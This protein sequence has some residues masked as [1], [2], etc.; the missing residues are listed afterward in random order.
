MFSLIFEQMEIFLPVLALETTVSY[1]KK[2][3]I[4]QSMLAAVLEVSILILRA[5]GIQEVNYFKQLELKINACLLQKIYN[6]WE[7]KL[8]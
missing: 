1:L 6:S 7:N 5:N 8:L 3:K 2:I 4:N